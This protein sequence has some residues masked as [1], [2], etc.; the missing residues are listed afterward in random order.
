MKQPIHV[1]LIEDDPMVQEVNQLFIDKVAGFKVIGAAANG[2]EGRRKVKEL[3]PDLVLLDIF[4]PEEDGLKTISKLRKDQFDIDIIAVTA[5]ND[6][7]T[8]KKLLRHGVVDYIVKPFTFERLKLAL[9][10]YK[11][12]HVQLKQHE[13]FSQ[14]ELDEVR[15]QKEHSKTNELPKGLQPLTLKQI[16]TYLEK[17]D[18]PQSA[19][20]IGTEV[21]L[22]R[23]TVRRYLNYLE[24]A[25]QVEMELTYGTIGRPIQLYRLHRKSEGRV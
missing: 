2:M 17:I 16:T 13:R 21:G 12:M 4:M 8:V 23:V 10:Q 22:A 7:D 20:E 11:G 19:E 9:E 6:T 25:G 15:Q 18:R 14:N 24:S 1:L 3:R 5:A